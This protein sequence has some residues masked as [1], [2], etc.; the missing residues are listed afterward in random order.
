MT[1][2]APTP[3]AAAVHAVQYWV[4]AFAPQIAL[5]VVAVS[6]QILILPPEW[7]AVVPL[8]QVLS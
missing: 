7:A 5:K 1:N 3:G 8:A 2:A 4:P 6:V